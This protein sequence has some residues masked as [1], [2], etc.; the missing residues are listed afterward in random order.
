MDTLRELKKFKFVSSS[1]VQKS[2]NFHF[3]T[4]SFFLQNSG[5]SS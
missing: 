4:R 2:E 3:D 1:E 5:K